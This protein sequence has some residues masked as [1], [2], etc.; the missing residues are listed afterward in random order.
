MI[1]QQPQSA[2]YKFHVTREHGRCCVA[3]SQLR[4]F[5]GWKVY[6]SGIIGGGW[7]SLRSEN[8]KTYPSPVT[9]LVKIIT[10]IVWFF[11]ILKIG[12]GHATFL[13]KPNRVYMYEPGEISIQAQHSSNHENIICKRINYGPHLSQARTSCPLAIYCKLQIRLP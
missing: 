8:L 5:M 3:L 12:Q 1:I 9:F 4:Q 10:F 7:L 2:F 6:I 11:M 13:K